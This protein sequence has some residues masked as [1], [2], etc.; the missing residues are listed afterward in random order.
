MWKC[1]IQE[2]VG[3]NTM[4]RIEKDQPSLKIVHKRRNC[5][6]RATGSTHEN[7]YGIVPAG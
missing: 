5:S 6:G 2:L 7:T 1:E 4:K 3:S